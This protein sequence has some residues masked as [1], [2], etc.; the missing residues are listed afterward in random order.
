MNV[1]FLSLALALTARPSVAIVS[2]RIAAPPHSIVRYAGE[3]YRT[4]I[5]GSIELV[6]EP[7]STSISVG[8]SL[9]NLPQSGPTDDFGSV[10]VSL[11]PQSEGYKSGL[12]PKGAKTRAAR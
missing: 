9:Y 11:M 1:M 6:A 7:A 4:G 3:E 2:Y 10:T 12:Q 8:D 5:S